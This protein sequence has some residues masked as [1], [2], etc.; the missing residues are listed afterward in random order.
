MTSS[1]STCRQNDFGCPGHFGHIELPSPVY[2]PLFLRNIYTLLRGTCLF[3][4]H[5][6]S[7]EFDVRRRSDRAH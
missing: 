7:A 2:H 1:C 3:C 6:V 4:H 5:F